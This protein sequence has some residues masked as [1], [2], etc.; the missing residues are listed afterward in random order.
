M[1]S[2][3]NGCGRIKLWGMT[4][5]K[6]V[7]EKRVSMSDIAK[8]VGVSKNTVSLALRGGRAISK[9]TSAKIIAMAE[10]L[11]Y[12]KSDTIS[13]VMRQLKSADGK[14][15]ETIAMINANEMKDACTKHPTVPRYVEGVRRA[16]AREG[17]SIDEF[18]LYDPKLN[19]KK[20]ASI[21]NTRGIKG[22]IV[23]GLMNSNK[24]P[25]GFKNIWRDFKFVVTGIRTSNP[26]LNFTCSDQ[27]LLAYHA[28]MNAI[29]CGYKR[30]AL[31]LDETIDNLIEGRF[32]GGFLRAQMALN[33][34]DRID[35]FLKVSQAKKNQKFFD[36]WFKNNKPD[37]IICLYNSVRK[38]LDDMGLNA[39]KDIGLIQLERRAGEEDWSGMEQNNDL[40]GETAVEKLTKLLNE[41]QTKEK[42]PI[43]ATLVSPT[44]VESETIKPCKKNGRI[45]AYFP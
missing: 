1:K 37:V 2:I 26:T 41:C 16:A 43:T 25:A 17:F 40:V 39:P 27:F 8:A 3:E 28:T 32:S 35:P 12:Q 29:A 44:W 13:K 7:S 4:D 9:K 20:L 15:R 33:R 21:L 14:F 42:Y 18:W 23:V 24:L 6:L 34:D 19:G 11:G 30:P 36:D 31:V 22:G 10:K 45:R 38:W 5:S